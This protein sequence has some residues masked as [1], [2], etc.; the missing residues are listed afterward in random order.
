LALEGD[1]ALLALTRKTTMRQRELAPLSTILQTN[2][3]LIKARVPEGRSALIS[4]RPSVRH[5]GR[6]LFDKRNLPDICF[7]LL[8]GIPY[9]F[10]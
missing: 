3:N 2:P 9:T 1:P 6:D 5:F 7:E 8:P 4:S 10:T